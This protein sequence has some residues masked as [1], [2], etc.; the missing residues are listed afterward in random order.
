[1]IMMRRWYIVV[2]RG[3]VRWDNKRQECR[4]IPH[5][6]T[7]TLSEAIWI[8]QCKAQCMT[9]KSVK[10]I[11]YLCL[12]KFLVILVH[13]L[14]AATLIWP[15]LIVVKNGGEGRMFAL[16]CRGCG[17]QHVQAAFALCNFAL[18]IFTV[19]HVAVLHFQGWSWS[20]A[21][22]P[23]MH[24]LCCWRLSFLKCKGEVAEILWMPFVHFT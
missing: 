19:V 20:L 9:K 23:C 21:D 3:G 16:E 13:I 8:P 15:I 24:S 1:M 2:G 11:R 5:S 14:N 7:A 12:P 10:K 6:L 4:T 18:C 17:L 22:V